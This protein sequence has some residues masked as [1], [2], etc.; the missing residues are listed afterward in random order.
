MKSAHSRALERRAAEQRQ[1]M[2]EALALGQDTN[3]YWRLVGVI[4]GLDD[5]MKFSKEIDTAMSGEDPDAGH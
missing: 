4:Q 5:A 2:L 3:S 1:A